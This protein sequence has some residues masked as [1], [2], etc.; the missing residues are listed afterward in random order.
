ME[1]Q[2]LT[3][4]ERA[5]TF[6]ERVQA[7]DVTSREVVDTL[8][9][10]DELM[11]ALKEAHAA[12]K[13]AACKH[14]AEHG[15]HTEGETVYAATPNKTVKCRSNAAAMDHLL[16]ATGGDVKAVTACLASGAIKHGAFRKVCG[17]EA[18]AETFDETKTDKLT[19]KQ[20]PKQ[21][22]KGKA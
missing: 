3:L 12:I 16:R 4:A 5:E 10:A 8:N 18:Y 14:F 9:A 17:E 15:P 6:A 7:G 22:T 20:I 19:V 11:R 1:T 2:E 21:L 13:E